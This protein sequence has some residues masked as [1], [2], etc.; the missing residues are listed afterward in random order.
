[1]VATSAAETVGRRVAGE[2]PGRMRA[3]LVAT[4]VGFGVATMTYK[5]LRSG[6]GNE[7]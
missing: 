4:A 7:T 2:R 1:M 6:A 3:L 5:L